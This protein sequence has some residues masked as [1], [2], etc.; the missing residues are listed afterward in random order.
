[1]VVPYSSALRVVVEHPVLVMPDDVLW[2]LVNDLADEALE[3][4][5]AAALVRLLSHVLVALVHDLDF[6]YCNECKM[7]VIFLSRLR[8][9]ERAAEE[10][11]NHNS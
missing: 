5:G 6:R 4:D 3:L 2:R 1:M 10:K 7:A 9:T 11:N 8:A